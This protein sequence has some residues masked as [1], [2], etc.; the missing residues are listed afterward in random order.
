MAADYSLKLMPAGV[1]RRVAADTPLRDILFRHG[2]EFPCGG[3]GKCAGC[4]VRLLQGDLPASPD[5]NY[6]LEQEAIDDGWRLAC[7][8]RMS[9]DLVLQVEQWE[10]VILTDNTAFD[11]VPRQGH[12]VAIDL[13]TTTLAA[14]L[15]DLQLGHVLAVRTAKNPQGQ[16]G[17]DIMSR[18]SYAM[19]GEGQAELQALIRQEIGTL[20]RG[21]LEDYGRADL[22][23]TQ[24]ILVGNTPMHHLFC[25]IDI[26][27]LSAYPFEPTAGGS[28]VLTAAEL[29]WGDLAGE[30]HIEFLP[31]LGSFVGSDILAGLLATRLHET[32]ELNVF[33]DL[34]TNGEMVVGNRD[35]LICASTAVGPAFEGA[36]I[37]KG[38]QAT[39]GAI[40]EVTL[41]DG[42]LQCGVIGGGKARGICGSGLVDAAACA[43]ELGH[44]ST[45]GRFNGDLKEI[46]L[47]GEVTLTQADVRELQ[48]AK[49]AVA[50]GVRI[51][52]KQLNAD[53]DDVHTVYIAGAFGN[54]IRLSSAQRIGLIT[55]PV[56]K[57]RPVGNTALLGAKLALFLTDQQRQELA[58][59]HER[60]EHLSL[61][62]D[63][64]FQDIYID[65]MMY[66]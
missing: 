40:N 60:V 23:L 2:I 31:N 47:A 38:M 41:V 61:S 20:I 30:P 25:G 29:G 36:R 11:F 66:D 27:P 22:P 65:E 10:S 59:L 35:R 1:V 8:H 50:A 24:I 53:L 6:R 55:F 9:G 44:V 28:C 51:L 12:G 49:G 39:T 26:S 48:L 21:L 16:H 62:T 56:D 19:E 64:A 46:P 57:V 18:V 52:L 37:A 43:L 45:T 58:S 7:K 42:E 34:G 33:I 32:S 63:P 5:R 3:R 54:Y 13:G 15:V 4:R 17:A 14:Q